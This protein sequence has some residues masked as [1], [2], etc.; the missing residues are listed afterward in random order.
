MDYVIIKTCIPTITK[1]I[2]I[3][4]FRK[5]QSIILIHFGDVNQDFNIHW[6]YLKET[7]DLFRATETHHI[8]ICTLWIHISYRPTPYIK[9][10]FKK[11]QLPKRRK[12][13]ENIE[14]FIKLMQIMLHTTA[15]H[16]YIN[17]HLNFEW[18]AIE[19]SEKF[20]FRAWCT[21]GRFC[22]LDN[23]INLCVFTAIVLLCDILKCFL[24]G[25]LSKDSSVDPVVG[26]VDPTPPP[27]WKFGGKHSV[28]KDM[29][30]ETMRLI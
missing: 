24:R 9:H 6:G 15:T 16:D 12:C 1:S 2:L 11:L 3:Y 5:Q 30:W 18:N 13:T 23:A 20:A 14:Y 27:Q 10:I 21:V 25:F 19:C 28:R 4:L 22:Y 8:E 7:W 29:E 17:R 26:A